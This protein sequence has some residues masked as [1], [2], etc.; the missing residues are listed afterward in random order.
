MRRLLRSI[1][2]FI[3]CAVF[4]IHF[5]RT[6]FVTYKR[7]WVMP[8]ETRMRRTFVRTRVQFCLLCD[9]HRNKVDSRTVAHDWQNPERLF[10]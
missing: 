1:L 8:P 3:V 4:R 2:R 10:T 9:G 6:A 7:L 5:W